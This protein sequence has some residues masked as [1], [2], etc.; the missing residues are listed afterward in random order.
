MAD[1]EAQENEIDSTYKTVSAEYLQYVSD[2]EELRELEQ[3]I[4]ALWDFETSKPNANNIEHLGILY[5]DGECQNITLT[6]LNEKC[7]IKILK[8]SAKLSNKLRKEFCRKW[9]NRKKYMETIVAI[10][11]LEH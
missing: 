4:S 11:E 9:F 3:F 1:L 8:E 5:D 2:L 10:Y 7:C 6:P